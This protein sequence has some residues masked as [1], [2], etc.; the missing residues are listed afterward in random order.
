M[1]NAATKLQRSEGTVQLSFKQRDFRTVLGTLYQQGCYQA[2]FPKADASLPAEAVLINTSGGLTDGDSLNLSADWHAATSA[3]ISSQAAERIYRSRNDPAVIRTALSIGAG[4]T[5]CW[6]PQET[7][8]FDGGRLQRST[9]VDM[10]ESASLF[11]AEIVVMGRTAMGEVVRNAHLFDRW[12]IRQDDKLIF[13][14]ALLFDDATQQDLEKHLAS[15]AIAGGAT[16]FATLVYVDQNSGE[17]L[18]PIRDILAGNDVIGGASQLG[19]LVV[20]RML[21]NNSQQMRSVVAEIFTAVR[22]NAFQLPRVW[23]C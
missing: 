19:S 14:D 11:A 5:A 21:A 20:A 12:R 17:S 4:A 15:D 2:R 6:L 16:C 13:A 18:T 3:V 22:G 8:V 9:E 7:I 10:A 1:S 23:N